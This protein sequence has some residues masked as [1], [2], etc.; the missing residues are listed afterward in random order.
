MVT[1]VPHNVLT[2]IKLQFLFYFQLFIFKSKNNN[3]K[4]REIKYFLFLLKKRYSNL[5][6][7]FGVCV[8][9]LFSV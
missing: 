5:Y 6:N 3:K 2:I 9:V 4:Y 7:K 1:Y 8:C